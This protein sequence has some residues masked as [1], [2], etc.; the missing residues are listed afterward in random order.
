LAIQ[1]LP[2]DENG[3]AR[4]DPTPHA[5]SDQEIIQRV[6]QGDIEAFEVLVKRH[7]SLVF[8]VVARHVPR[9]SI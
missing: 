8:G 5:P 6:V 3:V 4:G 1:H 7:R 2:Q 9:E